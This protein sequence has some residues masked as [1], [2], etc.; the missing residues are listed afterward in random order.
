M[1]LKQ[2][3]DTT[4]NTYLTKRF[5]DDEGNQYG[6]AAVK[7]LV[8]WYRFTAST[9]TNLS[10]NKFYD[11]EST[12]GLINVDAAYG[13]GGD[14]PNLSVAKIGEI[15]YNIAGF[16]TGGDE[17]NIGTAVEW[18]HI[19]GNEVRAPSA[20]QKPGGSTQKMTLSAWV[21]KEVPGGNS[22]GRIF[23]FTLFIISFF[24]T[25]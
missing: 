20:N 11:D 15:L 5:E 8:A 13:S 18:D 23:K 6:D 16:E 4:K 24:S 25:K 19:I 17:I 2:V 21:Y 14:K 10:T 22:S 7:S 12:P 3:V 1:A 9:P